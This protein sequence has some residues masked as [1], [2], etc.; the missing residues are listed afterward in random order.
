MNDNTPKICLAEQD[1]IS[2][3]AMAMADAG[4]EIKLP[5]NCNLDDSE[6]AAFDALLKAC[7][8][9]RHSLDEDRSSSNLAALL[10]EMH[11]AMRG[12]GTLVAEQADQ[13]SFEAFN[14]ALTKAKYVLT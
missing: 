13:K 4:F 9:Y 5:W 1:A 12:V 14:A 10:G 7:R 11:R 2:E 8:D 6:R 3:A